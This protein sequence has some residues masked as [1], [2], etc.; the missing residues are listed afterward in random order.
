MEWTCKRTIQLPRTQERVDS[1][2]TLSDRTKSPTACLSYAGDGS[3]L[4]ASLSTDGTDQAPI[5]HFINPSTGESIPKSGFAATGIVAMG[6]QDQYFIAVS[7][8]AAY[9]WD[10]VNDALMY[11]LKL[12][13]Q[14]GAETKAQPALTID[15]AGGTFALAITDHETGRTKVSV[16][17]PRGAECQY[18]E[19]FT[20]PVEAVLAGSGAKGYTLLFADATVR[21]MSPAASVPNRSLRSIESKLPTAGAAET[22]Q[23]SIATPADQTDEDMDGVVNAGAEDSRRAVEDDEDD[24]PVVRPEQLANI[25]DTPQSFAL[26]PVREIFAAVVGLF[27]RQPYV[28]PQTEVA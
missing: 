19:T 2:F 7:K 5:V 18:E 1:P 17:K 27:G 16:Y 10:L 20:V 23:A 6:F 11:K 14:K 26:P 4:A 28:K 22:S 3:M 8:L 15:T 21:T 13:S 12:A 24:R 25:F 9:I